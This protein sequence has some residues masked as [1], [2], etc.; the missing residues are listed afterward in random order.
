MSSAQL[1]AALKPEEIDSDFATFVQEMW[2]R[3]YCGM[4]VIHW[5]G[6]IPHHV[7]FMVKR[8]SLVSSPNIP[9]D[10]ALTRP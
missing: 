3:R 2:R 9:L 7:E 1:D 5:R 4:T 6:G 10:K 8:V